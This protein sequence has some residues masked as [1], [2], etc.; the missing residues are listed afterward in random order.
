MVVLFIV[1]LAQG[2]FIKKQKSKKKFFKT[3][4]LARRDFTV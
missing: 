4:S 2:I 1:V 3:Y